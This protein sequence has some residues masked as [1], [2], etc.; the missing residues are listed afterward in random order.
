MTIAHILTPFIPP[1]THEEWQIIKNKAV[2]VSFTKNSSIA[3]LSWNIKNMIWNLSS[4]SY[5]N[6]HYDSTSF[7]ASMNT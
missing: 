6:I 2:S 1:C 5:M 3:H 7:N 4:Q